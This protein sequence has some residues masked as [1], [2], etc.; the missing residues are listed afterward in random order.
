MSGKILS[1]PGYNKRSEY[2]LNNYHTLGTPLSA[3]SELFHS[4]FRIILW[5]LLLSSPS[6]QCGNPGYGNLTCPRSPRWLNKPSH[7]RACVVDLCAYSLSAKI[8]GMQLVFWES[9]SSRMVMSHLQKCRQRCAE[10]W[11]RKVREIKFSEWISLSTLEVFTA[12]PMAVRKGIICQHILVWPPLV[13]LACFGGT[14]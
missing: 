3:L 13:P 12:T 9:F 1:F 5:R 10:Q 8:C 4:V 11:K 6:Y 7:S 2:F 14:K